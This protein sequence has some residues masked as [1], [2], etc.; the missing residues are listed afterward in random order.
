VD[1]TQS[2]ATLPRLV[3]PFPRFL[4]PPAS[5]LALDK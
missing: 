2:I 3:V 5:D 4:S 1:A